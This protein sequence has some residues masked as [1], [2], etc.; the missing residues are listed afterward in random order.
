MPQ[1]NL[2]LGGPWLGGES[3]FDDLQRRF[4]EEPWLCGRRGGVCLPEDL[5][6]WGLKACCS[7]PTTKCWSCW[8]TQ[9]RTRVQRWG[10]LHCDSC[11]HKFTNWDQLTLGY[12]LT[13]KD[14]QMMSL[15]MARTHPTMRETVETYPPHPMPPRGEEPFLH[16]MGTSLIWA[17]QRRLTTHPFR[18]KVKNSQD[19]QWLTSPEAKQLRDLIAEREDQWKQMSQ[20]AWTA[21]CVSTV[22]AQAL[23]TLWEKPSAEWGAPYGEP[24]LLLDKQ[25][26]TL[27][28]AA[29]LPG[30]SPARLSCLLRIEGIV[31]DNSPVSSM[32]APPRFLRNLLV[33][34]GFS[35]WHCFGLDLHQQQA[36]EQLFQFHLQQYPEATSRTLLLGWGK[37][38][39]Q[40]Q[41][42]EAIWWWRD[43]EGTN[44][45][46][47]SGFYRVALPAG[48]D[49]FEP[50]DSGSGKGG[51]PPGPGDLAA[52]RGSPRWD[53]SSS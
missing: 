53:G 37:E 17:S 25:V 32:R 6:G 46:L 29:P 24:G 14:K 42:L 5:I 11:G 13:Q 22:W 31:Y 43:K 3:T 28:R 38:D 27:L 15:Q 34:A 48:G 10:T 4:R 52:R 1:M 35:L 16:W 44:F 19:S 9:L 26:A 49:T 30:F 12:R 21:T 45:Q 23:I 2:R 50:A 20:E 8:R 36:P 41:A 40:R 51:R 18:S 47:P 7:S 33:D 39:L